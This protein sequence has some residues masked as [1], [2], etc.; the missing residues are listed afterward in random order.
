[1]RCQSARSEWQR[2]AAR[3]ATGHDMRDFARDYCL[4]VS[5]LGSKGRAAVWRQLLSQR[6][7]LRASPQRD[8]DQ[9]LLKRTVVHGSQGGTL[10]R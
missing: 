3:R 6:V 2:V 9:V 4:S 8:D 1:M 7:G 5:I 10:D